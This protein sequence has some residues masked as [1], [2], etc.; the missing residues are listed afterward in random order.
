MSIPDFSISESD[1]QIRNT[2]SINAGIKL[3]PKITAESFTRFFLTVS[4]NG[5]SQ[6]FSYLKILLQ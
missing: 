1:I 6:P 3:K 2:F 4:V 5:V